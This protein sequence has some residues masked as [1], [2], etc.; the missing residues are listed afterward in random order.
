MF[1]NIFIVVIILL[2]LSLSITAI[3]QNW[4]LIPPP[5]E[6]DFGSALADWAKRRKLPYAPQH[7]HVISGVYNNRWFAIGTKNEETRS[8]SASELKTSREPV[9][10]SLGIGWKIRE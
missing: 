9:F 8:A 1:I 5:K 2:I 10:R 3:T 6:R 7:G 4:S